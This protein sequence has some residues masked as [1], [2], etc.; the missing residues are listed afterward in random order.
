MENKNINSGFFSKDNDLRNR[1]IFTVLVLSV[2]RLGTYIP[3]PGI[4]A[5]S[6]QT[7]MQTVL[8]NKLLSITSKAVMPRQSRFIKDHLQSA[9]KSLAQSIPL[10]HR[11]ST[12]WHFS[13]INRV[14]MLRR[15]RFIKDHSQFMRKP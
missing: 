1:I 9:R 3:L 13:T 14:A 10:S 4:D 11:V 7:M 2:Y 6:L 8:T 12:T 5:Q 15:S